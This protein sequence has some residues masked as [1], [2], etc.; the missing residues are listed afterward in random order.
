MSPRSSAPFSLPCFVLQRAVLVSLILVS[1]LLLSLPSLCFS[2]SLAVSN[3]VTSS[4]T[5]SPSHVHINSSPAG[6]LSIGA[7]NVRTAADGV[8]WAE[9]TFD[10]TAGVPVELVF[11]VPVVDCGETEADVQA[12]DTLALAAKVLQQIPSGPAG[13]QLLRNLHSAAWQRFWGVMQVCFGVA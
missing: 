11:A 3:A 10:T 9:I 5:S 2:P 6:D 12:C 7:T 4:V 8:E 1:R 13:P